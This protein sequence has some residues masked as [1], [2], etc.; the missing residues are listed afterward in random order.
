VRALPFEGDDAALVS[1]MLAG[2]TDATATFYSRYVKMVHGLCFRLMGPD[3]ELDDVVHDVFIRA[4]ESLARLRD[5]SALRSWLYGIAVH[6]VRI[7]FQKRRRQRW[8][9]FMAP[10]DV[11]EPWSFPDAEL[12]E[13]MREVYTILRDMDADERLALVLHRVEG[14]PL[15]DAAVAADMSLS[16]FRRRLARAESKFFARAGSKPALAQWLSRGGQD[17]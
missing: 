12:S 8:L 7:R 1:A 3:A 9:R 16:T 17:E 13:A 10:E 4:F 15:E 5:P 2:R 14:M 11:P 6:A